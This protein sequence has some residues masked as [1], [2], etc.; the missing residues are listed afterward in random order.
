M[1]AQA[2]ILL[3]DPLVVEQAPRLGAAGA[4]RRQIAAGADRMRR[5]YVAAFAGRP[6]RRVERPRLAFLQHQA[7]ELG[8]SP[9]AG[10]A[11]EQ[12]LGRSVPRVVQRQ[13]I[14]FVN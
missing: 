13:G 6:S 8:S 9:T 1:P 7:S 5:M 2:L 4:G 14:I 3:N 12:S 10:K 11:D